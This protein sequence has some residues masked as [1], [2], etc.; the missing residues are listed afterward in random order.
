MPPTSLIDAIS[1]DPIALLRSLI[2]GVSAILVRFLI[3]LIILQI[4]ASSLRKQS[5]ARILEAMEQK[6]LQLLHDVETRW[7]ST[8]LMIDRAILLRGVCDI[9]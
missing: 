4:R 2:R 3:L 5:F 7:S 6:A 8:Y 9:Y 1:R